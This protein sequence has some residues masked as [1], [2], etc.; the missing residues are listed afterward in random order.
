MVLINKTNKDA[1]CN[2]TLQE[3]YKFLMGRIHGD[4][5]AKTQLLLAWLPAIRALRIYDCQSC[6][7]GVL[8]GDTAE[9]HI[10]IVF[11]NGNSLNLNFD[12]GKYSLNFCRDIIN[13]FMFL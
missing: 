5:P 7:D 8:I 3:M 12:L 13:H 11:D 2:V 4:Y 9:A 6:K 10:V 1:F